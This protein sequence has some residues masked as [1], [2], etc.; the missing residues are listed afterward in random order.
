MQ[1]LAL[2]RIL[3]TKGSKRLDSR[4]PG[5]MEDTA[6][7]VCRSKTGF[8]Q[9]RG[10]RFHVDDSRGRKRRP[11]HGLA[12][13]VPAARQAERTD[14]CWSNLDQS[15]GSGAAARDAPPP[16]ACQ[17]LCRTWPRG[18]RPSAARHNR[19][20]QPGRAA[21]S[22]PRQGMPAAFRRELAG[23]S[24]RGAASRKPDR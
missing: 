10:T 16:S 21:R 19:H 2:F 24:N 5:R 15:M 3:R 11:G 6:R 1:S 23:H 17:R 8:I 20:N 14:D 12:P 9:N 7:E 22:I 18:T 4:K 13:P